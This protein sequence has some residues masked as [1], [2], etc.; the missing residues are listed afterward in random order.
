MGRSAQVFTA[1]WIDGDWRPSDAVDG[2]DVLDPSDESLLAV[3]PAGTL[4]DARRAAQ[5]ARAAQPRWAA[6]PVKDRIA[7][8]ERLARRLSERAGELA[9]VIVS[10]VGAPVTVARQAQVG[11]AVAM[12]ESFAELASGFAF[13]RRA[14]NSL[15]LREP[16]GVVAAIT[17]WNV[18]LLLTLQKVVPALLAGCAVVHKPS[19]LT[20]LNA[21]LLAEI[22]AECGLP[23]GVF[24]V[25]VGTGEGAGADLVRSPDVDMVSLTGSVRA[26]RQVASM[27]ARRVKRVHLELGG[28]NAGILL[29]DADLRLGVAATVDQMCFNTGQACLQWSRLLV[30]A[31]RHDEAAEL[32]AGLAGRYRVGDPRDPDTDLGPLISDQARERVRGYIASGV[33]EGATLLAGGEEAP[34]GRERGYY[35]RPTVFSDVRETMT[36]AK[37][38]IFGPVLSIMPYRDEDEAIE[39]ANNTPYGLHGAV[40]SADI[41]RARHVATRMRVGQVDI[42]GGPFN[43]L[44]PFGGVKQSGIGRECGVEGLEEFCETK[45][46]QLP[47]DV[48]EPVGPRLRAHA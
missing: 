20:P 35:V 14:G 41:A 31:D 29:D 18:P 2:I 7:F 38:E 34:E 5:A 16:A 19:E 33:A 47:V 21:Y 26:G 46:L 4:D 27:A 22:T 36:I 6:T 23:P 3:V 15:V 30:P 45:S 13:E 48:A 28:K 10:E 39:I 25:V 9:E 40:W 43:I 17:P 12:T 1:Q 32:A 24:N 37:E 11:L 44:A 8:V 42:N